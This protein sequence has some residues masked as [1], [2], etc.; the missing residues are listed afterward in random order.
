MNDDST[1]NIFCNREL[2]TR[3]MEDGCGIVNGA[4]SNATNRINDLVT[5]KQRATVLTSI[6]DFSNKKD[7]VNTSNDTNRKG[8]WPVTGT[9]AHNKLLTWK[10]P[11]TNQPQQ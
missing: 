11:E 1:D 8:M 5:Y 9:P 3:T 2:E 6:N 7:I 4:G 10:S